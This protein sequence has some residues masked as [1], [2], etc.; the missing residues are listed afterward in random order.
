MGYG[1]AGRGRYIGS[2]GSHDVK[3]ALSKK[4]NLDPVEW[5][6]DWTLFYG[7][8]RMHVSVS[9]GPVHDPHKE[10]LQLFIEPWMG[11]YESWTVYRHEAGAYKDGKIVFKKW[12]RE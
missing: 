1:L 5:R 6:P 7:Y 10:V 9:G 8:A 4:D 2:S 12:N 11:D 3:R